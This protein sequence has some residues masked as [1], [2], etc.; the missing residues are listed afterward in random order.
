MGSNERDFQVNA[1]ISTPAAQR[2]KK[3]SVRRGQSYGEILDA[4][5]LEVPI[6]QAEWEQPLNDALSEIALLKSQVSMLISLVTTVS[7]KDTGELDEPEL[8]CLT[9]VA[10]SALCGDL[11]APEGQGIEEPGPVEKAA[12][13]ALQSDRGGMEKEGASSSILSNP[14]PDAALPPIKEV[15]SGLNRQGLTPQQA[16]DELNRRGYRTKNNTLIKRGWVGN[17]MKGL[18]D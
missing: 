1:K 9:N 12:G 13:I 10:P 15:I 11:S 4:L 6:E 18:E 5:L 16:A 14:K 8:A 7:R 3:L 17:T 2:L